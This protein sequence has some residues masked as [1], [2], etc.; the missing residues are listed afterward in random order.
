MSAMGHKRTLRRFE[1]M[2]ALPSK[3]DIAEHDQDVRE[4]PK[5][6]VELLFNDPIC[7]CEHSRGN[8]DSQGLRAV[9][10]DCRMRNDNVD[11]QLL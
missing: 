5:A 4:V 7:S 2:S 3:A 10:I 8:C 11:A 9:Q 6:E 1:P